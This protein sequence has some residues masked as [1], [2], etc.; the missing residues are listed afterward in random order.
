MMSISSQEDIVRA[1]TS[2]KWDGERLSPSLFKGKNTSVSRLAIIPL[3]GHWDMFA[4][5]VAKPPERKL[6]LIGEIN[7]GKLQELGKSH[8]Q[9]VELTVESR[10]E[11]WNPAHAEVPQK[12]TKGLANKILP[13][14]LRHEPPQI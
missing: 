10:P 4:K 5:R 1:I 3:D 13:E 14:L 7:V 11:S 2:E 12:I 9:P 8:H 6:E